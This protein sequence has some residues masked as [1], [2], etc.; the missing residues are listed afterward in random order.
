M[1]HLALQVLDYGFDTFDVVDSNVFYLESFLDRFY[2]YHFDCVRVL[3]LCIYATLG[4][5]ESTT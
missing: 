4:H 5:L 2:F 1:L 3:V